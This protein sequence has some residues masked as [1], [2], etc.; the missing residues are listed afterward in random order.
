MIIDQAVM[1]ILCKPNRM[2]RNWCSIVDF[3]ILVLVKNYSIITYTLN[4]D[5]LIVHNIIG[6]ITMLK[7]N[8]YE[9]FCCKVVLFTLN[10]VAIA[11]LVLLLNCLTT[12]TQISFSL[13]F[14]Q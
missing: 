3:R 10:D 13:Q 7:L 4:F 14:Y 11:M 9:Y 12:I 6:F 8:F 1:F 2:S 5:P